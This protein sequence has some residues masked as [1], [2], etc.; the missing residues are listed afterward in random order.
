MNKLSTNINKW[1]SDDNLLTAFEN[2]LKSQPEYAINTNNVTV[3]LDKSIELFLYL[4]DILLQSI[5]SDVYDD[6]PSPFQHNIHAQVQSIVQN[7]NNVNHFIQTTQNLYYHIG[8]SSLEA[9]QK[10]YNNYK[11]SLTDISNLRRSYSQIVKGLEGLKDKVDKIEEYYISS[12]NLFNDFEQVKNEVNTKLESS[13]KALSDSDTIYKSIQENQQDVENAKKEIVAFKS[14]IDEYKEEIETNST[15]ASNIIEKFDTQKDT[16]EQ[17]INDAEKALMLKSSQGI[18]AALSTQY[19]L[20]NDTKK[21]RPWIVFSIIFL[22]FALFG[23]ILFILDVTIGDIKLSPEGLN[24]IV[25][26]VIF[27]GISLTGATFCANQYV[28][29]KSLADDYGF[30]LV[31]AKSIMAFAKELKQHDPQKAVDYMKSVLDEIN[32]S[33]VIKVKDDGLTK[34]DIGLFQKIFDTFIKSNGAQQ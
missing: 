15:T 4:K 7:R 32:R 16:V 24:A 29:Q 31:L 9:K 30:K 3:R 11:K 10:D 6:L 5:A 2:H 21:K 17:L 27:V 14:N 19:D 20:E 28:K 18:S 33:P 8:L 22:A 1:I 26:R 13:K 12:E 23:V 25:A 34:K